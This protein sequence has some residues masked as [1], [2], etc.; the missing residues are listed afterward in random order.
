MITTV[1]LVNISQPH[2]VINI[3]IMM[4]T[5]NIYIG[6]FCVYSIVNYCPHAGQHIPKANW[7]RNWNSTLYPLTSMSP[8]LPGPVPGITL[9]L[10]L[11]VQCC[12]IPRV[13]SIT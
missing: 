10:F 5:F 9:L 3:F 6:K 8:P 13:D 12:L 7:S 1:S 11:W 2:I 4:K